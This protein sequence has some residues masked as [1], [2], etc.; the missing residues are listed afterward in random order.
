MKYDTD[1]RR[2]VS[3]CVVVKGEGKEGETARTLPGSQWGGRRA[4]VFAQRRD[5]SY[6]H[7]HAVTRDS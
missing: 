1:E 2:K 6:R 5:E 3:V 7:T 4:R